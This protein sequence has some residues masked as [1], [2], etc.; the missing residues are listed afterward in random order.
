MQ[1]LNED[2]ITHAVI[3]QIAHTPNPRLKRILTS[4]VQ[5]LHNFAREVELSEDELMT[6]IQFLTR[7][8]QMCSD[9]RQEFILLSDTLGLSTLVMAMN[10]RKPPACTESTVFGPFH[11]ENAPVFP[12]GAD[13][14]NG[15][16]GEP[17]FVSG[18]IRGVDG[19]PVPHARIEV[20]QADEDG[21]YDVQYAGLGKFQG[22]GVLCADQDGRYYFR[23]IVAEP[24]P[25]P[26]DG[27]VG[28]MLRATERHPWRPAHLH[29]LIK[30][31]G[32]QTLITHIFRKGGTY[33]DS[34]AVF[35]VR[36]TLIADWLR[37]E[38]G[39]APDGS[40]MEVPFYT[41]EY[42]FVLNPAK[43]DS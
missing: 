6:A 14:A 31:T 16:K 40:I 13:V 36:S 39:R 37:H 17:C 18:V 1:N 41:L 25:I 9:K 21:Y 12:L 8:G 27:P 29:F 7:S 38:P 23:S 28:D 33:L 20:W 43:K 35:G 24:Y 30:Q 34:D 3:E 32:Y 2:T 19:E 11:V 15:A 5:H 4:L 26:H 10:N 22:R 42:D